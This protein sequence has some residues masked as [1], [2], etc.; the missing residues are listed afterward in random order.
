MYWLGE[1]STSAQACYGSLQAGIRILRTTGDLMLPR[2]MALHA[3]FRGW[4]QL[5]NQHDAGEFLQRFLAVAQPDACAGGWEVRLTNPHQVHD[6]G[7]L[8][9]PLFLHLPGESLQAL[10]DSW[11]HQFATHALTHHGGCI[12]L[13]ICRYSA[14][15]S[16]NM[17][18]VV[19]R[20]GATV[21]LPTEQFR[22][23]AAVFHQGQSTTSGHYQAIVGKPEAEQWVPYIC[24]DNRK[25]RKAQRRDLDIVDHNAYLVGLLRS[26]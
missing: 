25:P 6:S 15:V 20:P 3:L 21:T 4:R 12:F 19:I 11:Q 2:C 9:I 1:V 5:H 23:V 26:P 8:G 22:V 24:D 13:Q 18:R 14:H 7:D 16:K 10:V 17:Q